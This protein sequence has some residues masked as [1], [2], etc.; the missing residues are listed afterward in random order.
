[1]EVDEFAS[2]FV[3]F[4]QAMNEAA[5]RPEPLLFAKLQQH[6]GVQVV[7]TRRSNVFVPLEER[8]AIAN[9]E[10]ADLFL[11]IHANA[12]EDD[13]ARGIETYFLNFAPNP[14]AEA[15]AE[16]PETQRSFVTANFSNVI[17]E[18]RVRQK[19][20]QGGFAL[21]LSDGY[22][23]AGFNT[24]QAWGELRGKI[25]LSAASQPRCIR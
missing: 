23:V 5:G 19:T 24:P 6:P 7:M 4:M 2:A 11:S 12:S 3:E 9:R 25:P 20:L 18:F 8:T 21:A 16:M 1:M 14:A 15:I 13:R 17:N 22:L 10:G